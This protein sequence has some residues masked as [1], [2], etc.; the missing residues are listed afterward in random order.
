MRTV[1]WRADIVSMGPFIAAPSAAAAISAAALFALLRAPGLML[2]RPNERSLHARPVPRT[3]G[4]AIAAGALG[5]GAVLVPQ[6][7]LIIACAT[8]IALI[9]LLDDWKGLGALPR[10]GVHIV[11]AAIYVHYGLTPLTGLEWIFLVLAIVWAANLYNFMDGS[12][13][14]AAGMAVIGFTAYAVSASISGHAAVAV[15]SATVVA[16]SLPFLCVNF[17][18]ARIFMGDAGSVTLGFLAAALGT[19][20]WR[21]GAWPA[22]LPVFVFSPFI[23]DASLTLFRR[24]LG[25]QRLW[26]AHREHYYQRLIRMGLGHRRTALLEYAAMGLSAFGGTSLTSLGSTGQV[27]LSLVWLAILLVFAFIVDRRWER[28]LGQCVDN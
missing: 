25:R 4:I 26:Q 28:H 14:L 11:V 18:P 19:L 9:S 7:Q 23:L 2:D 13:G 17:H 5:A 8:A 24:M 15:M 3:G 27:A 16:A 6:T 1:E 10:I 22:L 12:D 21:E 20:G